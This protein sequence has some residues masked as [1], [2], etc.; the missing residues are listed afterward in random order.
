MKKKKKIWLFILIGVLMLAS[1]GF[2]ARSRREKVIPIQSDKVKREELISRV[3]ASGKI[4]PKKKV[5]ISASIP[6]K[7]VRLAV[8]EGQR[9]NKGDFLLQI[10]SAPYEAAVANARAALSGAR[11]DLDSARLS[12]KLAQQTYERNS[13]MWNEKTGL[14]SQQ[15]FDQAR[16]DYDVQQ[17][18]VKTA[19]H[20]VE[21][22]SANLQRAEDDLSKTRVTAPMSGIITRRP[23][24]EAE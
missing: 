20:Q 11:S 9:V 10:D 15:Q 17:T 14:I 21:Q 22:A 2:Y 24:E 7:I 12:L 13:R 5:D 4:Q 6:G 3:T 18:R 19:E 16:S 23:G 1:G 8:E